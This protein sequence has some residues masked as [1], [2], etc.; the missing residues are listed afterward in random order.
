MWLEIGGEHDIPC[1]INWPDLAKALLIGG[2]LAPGVGALLS[3]AGH[4]VAGRGG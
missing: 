2:L 4:G 3:V 1:G